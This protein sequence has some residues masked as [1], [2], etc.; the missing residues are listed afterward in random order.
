M[1]DRRLVLA[2]PIFAVA[3]AA[4]AA[5]ARFSASLAEVLAACWAARGINFTPAQIAARIGERVG[6]AALLAVAGATESADGDEVETAVEIVWEAG[7]P[8]SPALPLMARDLAAGL[9]LLAIA[10]TGQPLLLLGRSGDRLLLRDP[11]S[12]ARLEMTLDRIALIG[13]PVIAGA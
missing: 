2:L 10:A 4:M 1:I 5:P 9:P 6:K 8:P 3:P 7:Q 11:L 13:R 12:G